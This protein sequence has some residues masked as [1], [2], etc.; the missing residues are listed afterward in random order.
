MQASVWLMLLELLLKVYTK[1]CVWYTPFSSAL[2]LPEAH[3]LAFPLNTPHN[4]L[5]LMQH[6]KLD[7]TTVTNG[8]LN[9]IFLFLKLCQEI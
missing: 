5:L 1:L 8:I 7:V 2:C 4:A 3:N 9:I 6:L